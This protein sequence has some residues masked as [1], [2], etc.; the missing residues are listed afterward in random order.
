MDGADIAIG[1]G[2]VAAL[3][4]IAEAVRYLANRGKRSG[5]EELEKLCAM[6]Q[7]MDAK[8]ERLD[9]SHAKTDDM[10]RPMWYCR[11]EEIQAVMARLDHTLNEIPKIIGIQFEE[12]RKSSEEMYDRQQTFWSEFWQNRGGTPK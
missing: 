1:G 10:N 11:V 12:H 3:Y 6:V 8:L 7:T 9:A 2:A 5:S 4:A